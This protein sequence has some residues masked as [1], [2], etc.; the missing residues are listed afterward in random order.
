[1]F[2]STAPNPY[3][4]H[5]N[6]LFF[7]DTPEHIDFHVKTG[8]YFGFLATMMGFMEEGLKK[9]NSSEQELALAQE[10]RK[11]LRYIHSRYKIESKKPEEH[12]PI[13]PSGN[14]L[15]PS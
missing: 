8:D 9:C 2:P 11:D 3:S 12:T 7:R 1:M 14:L 15:R 10:L 6:L 4:I 13:R 5:G